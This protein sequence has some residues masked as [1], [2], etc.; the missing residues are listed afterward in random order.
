LASG[1]F[2]AEVRRDL[3]E[4]RQLGVTGVPFFVFDRRFAVSGA[5]ESEVFL[6]AL[7]EAW[8]EGASPRRAR[9]TEVP[10]G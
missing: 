6:R 3:L 4:S 10:D 9:G 2:A 5:Q 8:D 1:A 7:Q